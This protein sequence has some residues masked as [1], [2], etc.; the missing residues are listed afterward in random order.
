MQ[1]SYFLPGIRASADL[2]FITDKSAMLTRIEVG[3]EHR[4]QGIGSKLMRVVL[5]AADNEG[6]TLMLGVE[7]DGTGLNH[8]ALVAWYERLGFQGDGTFMVRNP[9]ETT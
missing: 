7:P 8:A 6:F 9:K 3:R 1:H 2:M 4:G 5:D